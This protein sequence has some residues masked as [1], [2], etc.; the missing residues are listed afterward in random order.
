MYNWG[1]A[2]P[3][4]WVRFCLFWACEPQLASC[5]PCVPLQNPQ[6][7]RSSTSGAHHF[8]VAFVLP[9][10]WHE[11]AL[12]HLCHFR[13][14]RVHCWQ[15]QACLCSPAGTERS[16]FP[17]AAIP[18]FQTEQGQLLV[19][20]PFCS[21]DSIARFSLL[22]LYHISN[23]YL[24]CRVLLSCLL[25]CFMLTDEASSLNNAFWCTCTYIVTHTKKVT[26][27]E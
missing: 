1:W 12:M 11:H 14:M 22:N 20:W 9:W 17:P 7:H 2:Q 26:K 27:C 23:I 8:Q 13:V 16:R 3:Q 18:S 19:E 25:E 24:Q 6:A 10:K 4:T 5:L 21:T 15:Y